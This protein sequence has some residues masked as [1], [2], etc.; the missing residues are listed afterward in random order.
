MINELGYP[1]S[2]IALEKEIAL[3]PHLSH[4]LKKD[5]PKRR[6]DI[7][8]FAKEKEGISPI[9]LIECKAVPFQKKDLQQLISYNSFVKASFIALANKDQIWCAK[10][11]DNQFQPQLISFEE[12]SFY[13]NNKLNYNNL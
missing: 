12:A 4:L 10:E 13:Y 2:L 3:L 5:I 9:L 1:R 6:V 7:L 11:E 8:V